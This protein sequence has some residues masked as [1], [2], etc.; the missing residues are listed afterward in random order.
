MRSMLKILNLN[1]KKEEMEN[2]EN[3]SKKRD[4]KN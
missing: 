1:L 2:K 4:I 3:E